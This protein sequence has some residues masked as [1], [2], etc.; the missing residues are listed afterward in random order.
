LKQFERSA[1]NFVNYQ[2]PKRVFI[3]ANLGRLDLNFAFKS[4]LNVD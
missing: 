1:N 2:K 4:A 3:K